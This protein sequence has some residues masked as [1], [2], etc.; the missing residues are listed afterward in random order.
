MSTLP[1][2]VCACVFLCVCVCLRVSVCVCVCLRVSVCVCVCLCVCVSVCLCVCVP[3]CLCLCLCL[4]VSASPPLCRR[5]SPWEDVSDSAVRAAPRSS[6]CRPPLAGVQNCQEDDWVTVLERNLS[7]DY[8]RP[9]ASPSQSPMSS[10]T[11]CLPET[12]DKGWAAAVMK[13]PL[14]E[15]SIAAIR[16]AVFVHRKH[17]PVRHENSGPGIRASVCAWAGLGCGSRENSG[18]ASAHRP[19]HVR[20]S[21]A[22]LGACGSHGGRP[23]RLLS[24][25]TKRPASPTSPATRAPSPSRWC[26]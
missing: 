4:C 5:L 11:R 1:L 10:N 23:S 22:G 21:R 9:C 20:L 18:P 3:V 15:S 6:P 2:C 24:T 19:L 7:S 26:W 25:A 12:S 14:A 8:V 16:V 17:L 13:V